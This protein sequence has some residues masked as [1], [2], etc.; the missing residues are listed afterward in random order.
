MSHRLQPAA[1]TLSEALEKEISRPALTPQDAALLILTC[2]SKGCPDP[3][4]ERLDPGWVTILYRSQR[5]DG[6]WPGE[7]LYGTPTRGEFA[8]WY[9][10]RSVTTALCYHA[11]KCFQTASI[12]A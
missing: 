6:S 12:S 1:Q 2:L 4:K 10:S 11:L 5:Y 9:A 7:P 8:S 3:V